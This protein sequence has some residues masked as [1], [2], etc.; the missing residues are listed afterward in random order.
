MMPML[1]QHSK[2]AWQKGE[3]RKKGMP[4]VY[5][6]TYFLACPL[7]GSTEDRYAD[8]IFE[9]AALHETNSLGYITFLLTSNAINVLE[10]ANALPPWTRS[11]IDIYVQREEVLKLLYGLLTKLNSLEDASK[12]EDILID[13]ADCVPSD[14]LLNR[15]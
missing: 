9:L 2:R 11:T 10:S 14:H 6:D 4:E 13:N 15:N 1:P 5:I 8:Y 3:E 12:I 7:D